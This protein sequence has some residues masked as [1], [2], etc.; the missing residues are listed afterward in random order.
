MSRLWILSF[1]LES[2]VSF[3]PKIGE[4]VEEM[5]KRLQESTE[6]KKVV[7]AARSYLTSVNADFRLRARGGRQRASRKDEKEDRKERKGSH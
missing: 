1:T 2:Y 5:R 7:Q 3:T 6:E 4:Y